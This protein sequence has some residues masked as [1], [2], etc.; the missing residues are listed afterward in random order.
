MKQL[1]DVSSILDLINKLEEESLPEA[2]WKD[3]EQD[4]HPHS[5]RTADKKKQVYD[6]PL[7]KRFDCDAERD[8]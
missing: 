3:Y 8:A 2:Y 6:Y 5:Y 7:E 1:F 4:G